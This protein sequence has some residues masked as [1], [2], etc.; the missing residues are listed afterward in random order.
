MKKYWER[1]AINKYCAQKLKNLQG[2]GKARIAIVSAQDTIDDEII[3]V[4]D[5][6]IGWKL[7]EKGKMI[8][9]GGQKDRELIKVGIIEYLKSLEN[10]PCSGI[11]K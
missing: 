2:L 11:E 9:K 1:A 7:F 10:L 4:P 3:E 6:E 5:W 8:Q